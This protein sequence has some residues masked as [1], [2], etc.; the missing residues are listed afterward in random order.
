MSNQCCKSFGAKKKELIALLEQYKDL[1]ADIRCNTEQM[2]IVIL[3]HMAWK[4]VSEA[5]ALSVQQTIK[6]WSKQYPD[7]VCYCF[8]SFSTLLYV[9]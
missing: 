6:E 9:L 8:D 4:A 7:M 1:N 3:I 5:D 2:S